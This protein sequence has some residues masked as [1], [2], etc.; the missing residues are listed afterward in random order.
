[1]RLSQLIYQANTSLTALGKATFYFY[2]TLVV[3][4]IAGCVYGAS[5]ALL[6]LTAIESVALTPWSQIIMLIIGCGAMTKILIKECIKLVD[7][8]N[9]SSNEQKIS[10]PRRVASNSNVIEFVRKNENMP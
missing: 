10:Q 9:S 8:N 4:G 6:K 3:T 5:L 2:L 1:M 7:D